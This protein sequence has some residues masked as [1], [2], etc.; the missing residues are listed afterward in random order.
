MRWEG[1]VH[2]MVT[3]RLLIPLFKILLV[4]GL[5]CVNLQTLLKRQCNSAESDITRTK[6]GG[7]TAGILPLRQSLS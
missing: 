4:T 7:G 3:V 1:G 2:G 5:L 6:F